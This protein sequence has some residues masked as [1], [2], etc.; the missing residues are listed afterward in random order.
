[1]GLVSALSLVLLLTAIVVGGRMIRTGNSSG[2]IATA[3][4]SKMSVIAF[5]IVVL[6]FSLPVL[7]FLVG[8]LYGVF[9]LFTRSG[10]GP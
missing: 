8:R 5:S 3:S 2:K 6:L 9:V 10:S 4:P 7:Y 1:M